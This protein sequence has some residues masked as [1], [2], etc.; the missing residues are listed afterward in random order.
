MDLGLQGKKALVVASSRG[1]GKAVARQ[2]VLEGADV[3]LTSRSEEA[4]REVQQELLALGTG[5]R[6]EFCAADVKDKAD[7]EQLMERSSQ[8]F[9]G[10]IDILVNNA[11]G[12]PPASFEELDDEAWLQAFQ[13]NL[14][15]VVRLIRSALPLMKASGG[16][17]IVNL[18][19][20]SIKQPIP[21]LILSN[22]M[23]MGVLG[24][25][26]TLSKELGPYGI[27]INTIAPGKIET[28][29]IVQLDR[30]RAEQDG[31][32]AEEIAEREQQKIPLGRYGT[33]EEF[34][35]AV[36]FLLSGANT[37]I[38]GT[39]LVIDGGVMDAV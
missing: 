19:S 2:L 31:I 37:Y 28:D 12:P 21:G 14:L 18:T 3:M 34:A 26:K 15:S 22:T 25:T 35:K 29:R 13:L 17:H 33:P 4:L 32:S 30:K 9:G 27:L 38:T 20:S 6:V 24:M 5:S 1:L 8:L 16:G 11:G 36:V 10:R 7:I 23:R 39:A